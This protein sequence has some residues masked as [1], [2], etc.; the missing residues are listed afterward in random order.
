[1]SEAPIVSR[2]PTGVCGSCLAVVFSS[3]ALVL[4][5]GADGR[6]ATCGEIGGEH[7]QAFSGH[8]RSCSLPTRGG[9]EG[10]IAYV[11]P[12]WALT[13]FAPDSLAAGAVRTAFRV[14]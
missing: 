7:A 6:Q 4:T 5:A 13:K 14:L 3:H 2:Y 10:A 1:M 9:R 8:E 11:L 12:W